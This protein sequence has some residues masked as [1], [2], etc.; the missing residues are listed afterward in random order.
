MSSKKN[1]QKPTKAERSKPGFGHG[2][3]DP[4]KIFWHISTTKAHEEH[5]QQGLPSLPAPLLSHP[6]EH[7]NLRPTAAHIQLPDGAKALSKL[8]RKPSLIQSS[9]ELREALSPCSAPLSA[10]GHQ[11]GWLHVPPQNEW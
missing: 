6:N 7:Q 10:W 3:K 2:E 8:K 1:Y 9:C 5:H 11:Q 4:L